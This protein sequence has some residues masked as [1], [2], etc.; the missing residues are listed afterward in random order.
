MSHSLAGG[1]RGH[2]LID[3]QRT[4]VDAHLDDRQW[5]AL[6][7]ETIWIP[8]GTSHRITNSGKAVARVLEVAFGPFDGDDI[9][10]LQ[11]DYSRCPGAVPGFVDD[12]EHGLARSRP[13]SRDRWPV[14]PQPF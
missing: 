13:V 9:E 11:G 2:E 1:S 7:G 5:T 12:I 3:T 6:T 10:R 4:V 14:E 8:Q